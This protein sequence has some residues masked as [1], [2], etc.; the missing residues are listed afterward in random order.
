MTGRP[1]RDDATLRAESARWFGAH[2]AGDMTAEE[3]AALAAWRETVPGA[4]FH[5][6]RLQNQWDALA[7]VADD[8]A[9]LAVREHD[10]RS[11]NRPERIRMMMAA[12]AVA[13]LL[14]TSTATFLRYFPFGP[15][16]SPGGEVFRTGNGQRTMATLTDGSIVTLDAESEVRVLEMGARRRLQLTRGRAFFEVAKD[17]VHPF[18]VEA[19]HK[20]IR[21]VGTKFDVRLDAD[22]ALTVTL[23]E[24]KVAV[25][26]RTDGVRSAARVDLV[27]GG[28]L[29][30]PPGR[31]WHVAQV[32]TTSDTSWLTGRLTFLREPLA[33]AI[34]EVNR[35]SPRKI[36]VSDGH[37]PLTRIVGVFAAGDVD[38]FVTAL[39]MNGV[40]RVVGRSEGEIRITCRRNPEISGSA[41]LMNTR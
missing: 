25:E 34:A 18:L 17:R 39:E 9:I 41:A 35:Y 2:R 28:R 8:P 38:G 3:A 12:A 32:D 37:A 20:T 19:A 16:T 22:D 26:Q 24:G 23:V 36:V 40:A 30:A 13:L 10:L 31:I 29:I 33:D 7:A 14:V 15:Y 1:V 4:A 11:Y 21:A 5:F 6:D 27:A